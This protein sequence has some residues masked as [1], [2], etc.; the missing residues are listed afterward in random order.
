[1]MYMNHFLIF[2]INKKKHDKH[3]DFIFEQLQ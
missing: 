3:V 2:S 1:M